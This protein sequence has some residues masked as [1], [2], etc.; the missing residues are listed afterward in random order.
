V[1]TSD[2]NKLA[3]MKCVGTS[4]WNKLATMKCVGTS[5]WNKY[6]ARN[7]YDRI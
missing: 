5:D 7:E 6:I 2:W 4:D 3:T 1:G